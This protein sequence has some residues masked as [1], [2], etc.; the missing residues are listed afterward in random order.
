MYTLLH[1]SLG[2]QKV[3]GEGMAAQKTVIKAKS[4]AS[5]F[6]GVSAFGFGLSWRPKEPDHEIIKRFL[7]ALEDRR[8]LFVGSIYEQPQHVIKSVDQMR[9][10]ITAALQQISDD[11]ATAGSLKMLRAACHEFMNDAPTNEMLH[12][13]WEQEKILLSLG[14]LRSAFGMQIAALSAAYGID[15][16]ENFKLILPAVIDS[17]DDG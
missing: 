5:R 10:D 3:V 11:K 2:R 14:K 1:H 13:H 15:V 4:M 8:A 16:A 9:K 12:G 7:I 6:G 17:K